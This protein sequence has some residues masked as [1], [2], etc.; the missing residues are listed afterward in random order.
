MILN[1]QQFD[2]SCGYIAN[3]YIVAK[4]EKMQPLWSKLQSRRL[5]NRNCGYRLQSKTMIITKYIW[6]LHNVNCESE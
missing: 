6:I 5:E 4:N 2:L 3:F 1:Y